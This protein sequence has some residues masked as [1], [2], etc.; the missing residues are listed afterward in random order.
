MILNFFPERSYIV[1]YCSPKGTFFESLDHM[2]GNKVSL[3]IGKNWNYT[4][5]ILWQQWDG[6]KIKNFRNY[7]KFKI[8]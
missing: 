5:F 3:K 2:L 1:S 6:E 8:I 4:M 7:D